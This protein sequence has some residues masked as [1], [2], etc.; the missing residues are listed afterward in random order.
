MKYQKIFG[1]KTLIIGA[2]ICGSFGSCAS[3]TMN[4]L[5]AG[6]RASLVKEYQAFVVTNNNDTIKGAKWNA[7]YKKGSWFILIDNKRYIDTSVKAF[8]NDVS[9][10]HRYRSAE[11]A[12]SFIDQ[13][14][15]YT[16][17][18]GRIE[19]LTYKNYLHTSRDKNGMS[20]D[21][22]ENSICYAETNQTNFKRLTREELIK[23]IKDNPA[24]TELFNNSAVPDKM[25]DEFG[26]KALAIIDVYNAAN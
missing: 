6:H 16:R 4:A 25:N 7:N 26:K 10:A 18:G 14:A 22:Y 9:L 19:L 13:W 5:Y 8:Q 3:K 23:I 17:R 24:A 21:V 11:K 20:N 15:Y 2:I 12:H 1:F